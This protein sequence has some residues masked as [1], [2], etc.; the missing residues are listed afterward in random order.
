MVALSSSGADAGMHKKL[1]GFWTARL[2]FRYEELED[3][4]KIPS[5]SKTL[6]HW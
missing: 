2:V 6:I 3:I 1:L 4:I 5:P